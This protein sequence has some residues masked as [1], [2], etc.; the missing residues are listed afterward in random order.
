MTKSLKSCIILTSALVFNQMTQ[1]SH[2]RNAVDVS[3]TAVPVT[4]RGDSMKKEIPTMEVTSAK[5]HRINETKLLSAGYS[6]F[7]RRG[8]IQYYSKDSEVPLVGLILNY[9]EL[10]EQ[11]D[12]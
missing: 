2:A 9:D 5:S 10:R 4:L 6:K 12:G 1:I 7:V 3:I 8:N 11:G